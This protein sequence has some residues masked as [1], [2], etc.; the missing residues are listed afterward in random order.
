VYEGN[1][2]VY[3]AGNEKIALQSPPPEGCTIEEKHVLFVTYEPDNEE[4]AV[5]EMDREEVVNAE[6]VYPKTMTKREKK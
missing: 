6:I 5:Y 3:G 4:L 1:S 2:Q